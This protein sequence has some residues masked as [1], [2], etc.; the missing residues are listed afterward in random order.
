MVRA[1]TLE[2]PGGT[3]STPLGM[4]APSMA[5]GPDGMLHILFNYQGGGRLPGSLPDTKQGASGL[6]VA[7][8]AAGS[9]AATTR[10]LQASGAASAASTLPW[11]RSSSMQLL[12]HIRQLLYA[13]MV[14]IL[15]VPSTGTTA[16]T[17]S[18]PAPQ[19]VAAGTPGD[20]PAPPLVTQVEPSAGP[21]AM[22]AAILPAQG[23]RS[24]PANPAAT[25][26][27]H[28]DLAAEPAISPVAL[29]VQVAA[30]ISDKGVSAMTQAAVAVTPADHLL[31]AP[32]GHPRRHLLA[33]GDLV[34]VPA[35][36]SGA[37]PPAIAAKDAWNNQQ[38]RLDNWLP[39]DT[40]LATCFGSLPA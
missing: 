11:S 23:D 9:S 28:Q 5:I 35:S 14:P 18:L 3:A 26:A 33:T 10:V 21:Q 8:V 37:A 27:K 25:A 22:Q 19:D 36:E 31:A 34:A 7:Q 4:V 17:S 24:G 16:G 38:Q 6:A 32:G 39:I 2:V 12:P 20:G 15:P 13:G 1:G 29:P 40:N 30:I